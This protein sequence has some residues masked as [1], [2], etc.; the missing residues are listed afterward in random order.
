[1]QNAMIL[2]RLMTPKLV[3]LSVESLDV[4]S[5]N[6]TWPLPC[7]YAQSKEQRVLKIGVVVLAIINK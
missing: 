4:E 7:L 6:V 3:M 5:K 2:H 1:M